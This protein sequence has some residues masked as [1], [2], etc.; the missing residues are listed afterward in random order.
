M[1]KYLNKPVTIFWLIYKSNKGNIFFKTVLSFASLF[2][3]LAYKIRLSLYKLNILKKQNISAIVISI[4]NISSGGTGKTPLT[5]DIAKYFLKEGYKVAVLSRGYKR[6]ISSKQTDAPILVSDGQEI[7]T[8]YEVSGDEPYLIAK[9]VPKAM[10]LV[11]KNRYRAGLSAIKLGAEILILDDGYQ[12]IQFNRNE[13][14]LLLD[15]YNPFDNGY[16]LPR[17]KLRELPDSIKRATAIVLSNSD[18]SILQEND[19]AKINHFRAAKP[20]ISMKYKVKR[21]TALNLKKTI[22]TE[23]AK[24]LKVIAFC[25][26]GNPQSFLDT[27]KE[28]KLNIVNFMTFEDH[29]YYSYDDIKQIIQSASNH[30]IE[31]IVTTEKD[32]IKIETLCE[33][34]PVTFWATEIEI[35]WD[36]PNPYE[37][38]F[39]NK[40]SWRKKIN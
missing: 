6:K 24:G 39:A 26:I 1:Q 37:I 36:V 30:K 27:L 34:A 16:L 8:D 23:E 40:S 14:I 33:A 13:N 12:H 35:S 4:G 17:G 15:S 19:L 10:V 11:N 2:Y 5:I 21:F 9:K 7:I 18:K 32:A 20:V 3:F 31:N 25:G 38:L 28:N 29:H 22:T